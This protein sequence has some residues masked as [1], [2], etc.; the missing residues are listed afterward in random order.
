MEIERRSAA[1][2]GSRGPADG[3]PASAR[4]GLLRPP[5]LYATSILTGV[6]LDVAWPL[7]F[8]PRALGRPVGG[9][10]ALAAVVLFVAAVRQLWAAGTPVP[11][12]RPTTVL[13]RTGPYRI[14]RNPIYLAFSLLHLGVAAWVGSWW[15][16]A[17]LVASVTC[18]AAVVV[19]REE[20]YLEK[21]FGR[22]YVDYYKASVRRWL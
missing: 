2:G 21:R 16:L 5:F 3:G 1:P 13:V 10:L 15:L 17:T 8:V 14:S 11:G 20:R 12:N 6:L 18:I 4:A 22:A 9:A 7:S 19:P